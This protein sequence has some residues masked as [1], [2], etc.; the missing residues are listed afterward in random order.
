M[1][2]A[3]LAHQLMRAASGFAAWGACATATRVATRPTTSLAMR[4]EGWQRAPACETRRHGRCASQGSRTT[5]DGATT[6][7][8]PPLPSRRQMLTHRSG[9]PRAR[10]LARHEFPGRRQRRCR[11]RATVPG[12]AGSAPAATTRHRCI[13][14]R[15][16]GRG[17]RARSTTG[18]NGGLGGGCAPANAAGRLCQLWGRRWRAADAHPLAGPPPRQRPPGGRAWLA[19]R[20]RAIASTR[21]A[22][23]GRLQ[24]TKVMPHAPPPTPATWQRRAKH[25]PSG[26]AHA[27]RP[28]ARQRRLRTSGIPAPV[29][30]AA[31]D[32]DHCRRRKDGQRVGP[33]RCG[34]A[35]RH[36]HHALGSLHEL[37]APCGT[38]GGGARAKADRCC[39]GYEGSSAAPRLCE[40]RL[41]RGSR[42]TRARSRPRQCVQWRSAGV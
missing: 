34:D 22:S 4:S 25:V 17:S 16:G 3:V 10:R 5:C 36:M 28:R 9:G 7:A 12:A 13:L 33:Q 42:P 24:G 30:V 31:D 20:A 41:W 14:R 35:E 26:A 29:L 6:T 19:R 15:R 27:M 23:A 32:S 2:L 18:C 11:P 21:A 38:M 40:R 8:A 1:V 37:S 39:K